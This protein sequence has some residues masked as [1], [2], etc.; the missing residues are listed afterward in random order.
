MKGL[1]E[2]KKQMQRFRIKAVF[3]SGATCLGDYMT[4]EVWER[5]YWPHR[6]RI[7]ADDPREPKHTLV[8]VHANGEEFSDEEKR[9]ALRRLGIVKE[10]NAS[11][12]R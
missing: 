5:H 1:Q 7:E 9:A 11:T 6:S 2:A 12:T 8:P 4:P 10:A 3:A